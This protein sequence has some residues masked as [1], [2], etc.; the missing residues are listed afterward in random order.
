MK[1]NLLHL[2]A[3]FIFLFLEINTSLFS[4]QPVQ[5]PFSAD[6]TNLTIWN[7]SEYIPFFIKGIN[8]GVAV[9]GTFPGE[10]AATMSDYSKWFKEIKDAGFNCIRVYTLHFP[11]FFEAL[12]SYNKANPQ[13]P[14]LFLQGVWLEEELPGYKNDLYFLSNAFR[15]E[16]EENIDCVHG[17]RI[18]PSRVGKAYGSY[19]TD[20]SKW[21]LGYIIGREVY[22]IEVNTTN[23]LNSLIDKYEGH[24]FII[25]NASASEA[26]L[27]SMLDYTLN[28]E[29]SG[30]KTQR[31]VSAS[32]W[33]T[34][35]PITHKEEI[36]KEE[37]TEN[38]DLSKIQITSLSKAGFFIS[39]HAYPYYPDFVGQQ[40]SYQTFSDDYGPNSYKGYLTDLKSHYPRFPLIIAE[41]GVPSSWAIAHYTSSGMNHGGFDE[42]NQGLT[43][44]RLLNTIKD[45]SCGG[46]IQ[47]SWIDEWF[48]K[49]WITDPIDYIADSR[50]LW[51]NLA[52]AEQNFGLVSFDKEVQ[53][54]T[55]VKYN[56]S[57]PVTYVNA[58]PGYASFDLE[59][60]LKNPLDIPDQMWIAL[61]TYS[62]DLGESVLPTGET[63]PTRSEFALQ[64]T[65]YSAKLYVTQAYDIFGIW[66]KSS[67]PSQLYH[68]I[69]TD[70]KPWNIVRIRNN[71][72]HSDVQYIGN[73]Q[74]NYD[75]QPESSKDAITISDDKIIVRI[76]W[77]YINVVSPDQMKVFNDNK[78]TETK[79]DT[80]SDGFVPSVRYKNKWYT[81]V[82]RY[83][84]QS[85]VNISDY[86]SME[87][88]KTSYYVMQD[89]LMKFNTSAIAVRDSFAFSGPSFPV[90]VDV[91]KGILKND[92][93]LDGNT[94]VSLIT[95][96]PVNGQIYLNN[97]GSFEYLPNNGFTGVDSLKY[98]VYDGYTLSKSNI[99]YLAVDQNL[100]SIEWT[101]P[102]LDGLSLTPNPC[103]N[104]ITIKSSNNI[105][106]LQIFNLQ[107]K[108]VESIAMNDNERS[109]NV[110]G[111]APGVYIV[112]ARTNGIVISRKIIKK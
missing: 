67:D 9:P 96:N 91:S 79:E 107:G 13:N 85:W 80:I 38:I 23:A 58:K 1:R 6:N 34:L 39:Y 37:D 43:D 87:K 21:C 68:S 24:Y 11:R 19:T 31:P 100:S 48:K 82:N 28:Y 25:K 8:L 75:F 69:P 33:P 66:H 14:L 88:L 74:V 4:Q 86:S 70:G 111:Y 89:N 109:L 98:C 36:N 102:A 57:E 73:F 7:G 10:M 51:H 3:F 65:N 59:I 47:F 15:Q 22:P 56:S 52:S 104:F 26:W 84:W 97:N 106:M 2:I 81:P 94:M 61:D 5:Y 44:I 95:E 62:K 63:I 77:S 40:S 93:D 35:D 46:G 45:T 53:K 78:N 50:I 55:L 103:S 60:G 29:Q 16:I 76:P 27:T 12:N 83:K 72:L 90:S 54:D 30:Y 18:I 32:S 20:I 99:V 17:N 105:E 41:Y 71:S 108:L 101:K 110:S 92:F 42:Y 49:T 64:I 112:V